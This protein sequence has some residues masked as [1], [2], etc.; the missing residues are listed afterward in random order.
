ML[1]VLRSYLPFLIW[2]VLAAC[3]LA[4]SVS[5]A[6]DESDSLD[7]KLHLARTLLAERQWAE[8][9]RMKLPPANSEAWVHHPEV[10]LELVGARGL[11]AALAGFQGMAVHSLERLETLSTRMADE[12]HA[13]LAREAQSRLH[14]LRGLV[15]P[16]GN[17]ESGV[18]EDRLDLVRVHGLHEVAI[19]TGVARPSAVVF[20]APSRDRHQHA[21]P[22]LVA[23]A[24]RH[25]ITIDLGHADVEEREFR[26]ELARYLERLGAIVRDPHVVTAGR[27][28]HR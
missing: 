23:Q 16:R 19:E 11:G 4:P 12:G 26:V 27:K 24:A 9:A 8:V 25:F 15:L 22:S 28:Q 17:S 10:E 2:L 14:F 13:E 7:T 1:K 18:G 5:Q 21:A 3:S 6:S 20:L